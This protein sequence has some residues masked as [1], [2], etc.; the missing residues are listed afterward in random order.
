MTELIKT[1]SGYSCDVYTVAGGNRM[2]VGT[3]APEV[4]IYEE[5]V[6]V[7][8]IG[9]HGISY[10]R[11]YL[12]VVVCPDPEMSAGVTFDSVRRV[13][14]FDLVVKFYRTDG[15]IV[16]VNIPNVIQADLTSD[17]WRFTITDPDTVKK[18]LEV[19]GG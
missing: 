4:E 3:A 8:T 12:S 9:A 10:K 17:E 14:S 6:K 15:I 13:K 11:T 19:A 7:P 1:I 16:Q 5:C 2:R 18:I